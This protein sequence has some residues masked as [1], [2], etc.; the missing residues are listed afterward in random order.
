[1]DTR[2]ARRR[3]AAYDDANGK[4]LCAQRELL[5]RIE[6]AALGVCGLPEQ[7][8]YQ[9]VASLGQRTLSALQGYLEGVGFSAA[10]PS[11][12][13]RM[14]LI[15]RLA[16]LERLWQPSPED[17]LKQQSKRAWPSRPVG[18]SAPVAAATPA[19]GSRSDRETPG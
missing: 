17:W 3:R 9:A 7:A 11:A 13:D 2:E 6:L 19:A 10:R 18:L 5:E 15:Q 14:K 8:Q 4:Y 12:S 16:N 1:M